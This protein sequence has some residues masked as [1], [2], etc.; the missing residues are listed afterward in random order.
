MKLDYLRS[1]LDDGTYFKSIY[2]FAFDFARVSWFVNILNKSENCINN[3]VSRLKIAPSFNLLIV[4][5]IGTAHKNWIV[6][7]QRPQEHKYYKS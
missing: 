1:I 5:S 7:K 6:L 3:I 4:D 2:R